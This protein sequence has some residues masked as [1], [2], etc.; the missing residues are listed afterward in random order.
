[1]RYTQ[2]GNA[3]SPRKVL[4]CVTTFI[5]ISWVAS[6]ASSGCRVVVADDGPLARERIRELLRAH[7]DFSIV[8]E[9][10]DGT[11]TVDAIPA[12]NPEL[13]F[14]DIRMPGLDGLEVTTVLGSASTERSLPSVIFVTAFDE[15][16]VRAFDASAANYL[17][18]PFDQQRFDRA[19][20][21]AEERLRLREPRLDPE[22]R[23]FIDS[24]R[25]E[26]SFAERFLVRGH[27]GLYFIRTDEVDWVDAQGNYVR[28]HALG[29]SHLVRDTMKAFEQKL[30]PQRFVRVNRSVI[31]NIDHTARAETHPHG[32]YALML[33]DGVRVISSR[34]HGA[35][36]HQLLQ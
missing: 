25:R 33:R 8:A 36:L 23:A 24:V 1:M 28:L 13:L 32:E 10:E 18:K 11:A 31:V 20:H 30:D 15:F 3:L 7:P 12:H 5:R 14:L 2:V 4:R 16:A 22:L 27:Q 9:C 19:L 6:S 29:K 26:K 17:R 21:R 35:R 34:A